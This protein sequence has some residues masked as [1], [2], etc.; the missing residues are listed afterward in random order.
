MTFPFMKIALVQAK[1]AYDAGEVPVGAVIVLKGRLI[2]RA[3]N[4]TI[5]R[6]DPLAHAEMIAIKR[7]GFTLRRDKLCDL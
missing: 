2:A 5:C 7:A 3:H 1:L 4:S 6:K